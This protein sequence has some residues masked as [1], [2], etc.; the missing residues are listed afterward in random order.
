MVLTLIQNIALLV[1]LSVVHQWIVRRW[2]D[3]TIAR[4]VA[5]GLLFGAIAVVGMMTP[6]RAAAG[7]QYDGRSIIIAVAAVFGGPVVGVVA[8]LIAAA[9]RAWLGGAGAIA[10]VSVI[11][12]AAALGIAYYYMRRRTPKADRWPQ[13]YSLALAVHAIMLLLQYTLLGD[14][15]PSIVSQIWFPVLVLY[16]VGMLLVCRLMLDQEQHM[17]DE[18]TL[19]ELNE[20]LERMVDDRTQ[21]LQA[22]NEEL[23]AATDELQAA[24]Q[25]L[26]AASTELAVTNQRLGEASEAKSQFLRAMSHELRTPLNSVIGFSDLLQR[27]TAGEVNDEQTKQLEMINRSGRRL[28]AIVNDIL[29]L[30]RIEAKATQVAHETF[31]LVVLVRDIAASVVPGAGAKGLTVT[32]EATEDEFSV[33]SDP[34]K[35]GQILI[36]LL[37]NAVKF[38][39]AGGVTVRIQRPSASIIAVEVRDTGPGIPPELLDAVFTEFVQHDE[40]V[41]G[42][43]LGLAISR[44]LAELLGGT[45][46]LDSTLGEGAT[47]TLMLPVHPKKG[48]RG[49]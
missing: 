6:F 3:W 23:L 28:L 26:T 34:S 5:S 17:R 31:D 39:D 46:T 19:R 7:I 48:S 45:V 10:G 2:R 37:G 24:N 42:T 47:F 38:T 32:V 9:Y 44:S 40:H 27:G 20:S 11:V 49:A 21:E 43:G 13:I 36:N 29:D 16:P 35:V 33:E 15:G 1:A 30:S 22:T 18:T 4:Q 14:V 25:Q 41:E 8:A 12:E